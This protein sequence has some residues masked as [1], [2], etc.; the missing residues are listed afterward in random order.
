[1]KAIVFLC[2][3]VGV[4]LSAASAWSWDVT[5]DTS[6]GLVANWKMNTINTGW[7]YETSGGHDGQ[8]FGA[9]EAPYSSVVGFDCLEFDGNQDYVRASHHAVLA[10]QDDMSVTAWIRFD[11]NN[12]SGIKRIVTKKWQ[13]YLDI[14]TPDGTSDAYLRGH[15]SGPSVT[16]VT[17]GTSTGNGLSTQGSFTL[18]ANTWYRVAMVWDKNPDSGQPNLSLYV[19]DSLE[20]AATTS[21]A[22]NSYS[23]DVIIGGSQGADGSFENRWFDGYMDNVKVYNQAL[24]EHQ[25]ARSDDYLTSLRGHWAMNGMIT[26][27]YG[28]YV[29]DYQYLNVGNPGDSQ[30]NEGR[31]TPSWSAAHNNHRYWWSFNGDRRIAIDHQSYFQGDELT[32]TA[33]IKFN[34]YSGSRAMRVVC[35]K[36]AWYLEISTPSGTTNAYVR[37]SISGPTNFVVDP[38]DG[39]LDG[40]YISTEGNCTLEPNRWYAIGFKWAQAGNQNGDTIKIY[41]DGEVEAIASSTGAMSSFSNDVMIGS[42]DPSLNYKY[43]YGCIDEVRIYD[44]WLHGDDMRSNAWMYN[45]GPHTQVGSRFCPLSDNGE[46][47]VDLPPECPIGYEGPMHIIDGLPVGTSLEVDAALREFADV[48]RY[49]G[50]VLGGEVQQFVALLHWDVTGTGELEGFER[51]LDIPVVCEVHTEPRLPGEPVQTFAQELIRLEGQLMGDPDFAN[52]V[53]MSGMDLGLPSPGS[54]ML[55]ELPSGDFAVDSFFDITYQIEFEGSP[56][57]ML[58]GLAGMTLDTRHIRMGDAVPVAVG[59][60][61]PFAPLALHQNSPNPFNPLTTI[62][63]DIH[64][65][66]TSV[67]LEVFDLRG[68]LVRTLVD[69][70]QTAGSKSVR[71]DGS[72]DRGRQ[73]AAGVYLY[74]LRTD[75]GEMV[76]KMVLLK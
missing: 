10:H 11:A 1:M 7:I 76:R 14:Y 3:A 69:E 13:W 47:T 61:T 2:V 68:R 58:E 49:P 71:W 52:L 54:T 12:G 5:Y 60:D 24:N 40:N 48:Q 18:H 74:A 19:N 27:W 45:C 16:A 32:V 4:A 50:G 66:G 39:T 17:R 26:D 37:A 35:K 59:D 9:T 72:D 28:N 73:T 42:D 25:V 6:W 46:G 30:E 75:R 51:T 53:V 29:R 65:G 22:M 20:G 33:W 21:G 57:G 55:T 38:G 15:I 44:E 70:Y 41:V 67:S 63:Y 43:F 64:A 62:E 34:P 8:V 56:G 36:W 31:Y 23:Y